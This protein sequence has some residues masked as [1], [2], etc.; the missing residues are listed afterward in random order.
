MARNYTETT[1]ARQCREIVQNAIDATRMRRFVDPQ[2][3]AMNVRII[4]HTSAEEV[5][6]EVHDNGVGL[7]EYDITSKLL[8]FGES[9]WLR[10][11]SIGEYNDSFPG[12]DAVS[13]RYGIGF[14]SVFMLADRVKV[15]SRR[16][17]AS[18][19]ETNILE[20]ENGL[21][22][23][24]LLYSPK[25][26]ERMTG[27]GTSIRAVFKSTD[28]FTNLL[29][30]RG[31]RDF[32]EPF[33][34]RKRSISSFISRLFPA[35]DVELQVIHGEVST[36]I[37]GRDWMSESQ[38]DLLS[39]VEGVSRSEASSHYPTQLTTIAEKDGTTVGRA[40]LSP[41]GSTR[42]GHQNQRNSGAVVTR[43]T[44]ACNGIFR[45]IMLG[46]S[47]R[48]SRDDASLLAS[49]EAL[50]EWASGQAKLLA[51]L[52]YSAEDQIR[53]AE[54][55]AAF[56]GNLDR[57]KFCEVGGKSLSMEDLERTLAGKD[58]I[59]VVDTSSVSLA[60]PREPAA[61]RSD[62]SISV[63]SGWPAVIQTRSLDSTFSFRVPELYTL[64][65]RAV[66]RAFSLSPALVDEVRRVEDGQYVYEAEAPVW[67]RAD[68]Q[69]VN[70]R[71]SYLRRGMN[72]E[73][74]KAFKV[75]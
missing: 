52:G 5:A 51:E 58:E 36:I 27:G 69:V 66:G 14:F 74:L 31:S 39:R 17:D 48:A 22:G 42:A 56:G 44:L 25:D 41:A 16:F 65:L 8:S 46:A 4:F 21:H 23:R 38:D 24:P 10:D 55:V 53:L 47:A 70:E 45:G 6:L 34:D 9:G 61:E 68:G 67:T 50:A 28:L 40:G 57:L 75:M 29:S 73:D 43:G 30:N 12:D 20:F 49:P 11:S 15:K 33:L 35:V 3:P 63:M 13:G 54:Q 59:W 71:G 26:S 7:S 72:F 1:R 2:H 19:D 60:K 64:A 32:S 18:P 62:K 37:D